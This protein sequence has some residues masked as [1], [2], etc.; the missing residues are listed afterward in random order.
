M[1]SL[2]RIIFR[3]LLALM[4]CTAGHTASAQDCQVS[5]IAC[6]ATVRTMLVTCAAAA[7]VEGAIPTFDWNCAGAAAS[8]ASCYNMA[9]Y[10]AAD[11]NKRT[12]AVSSGGARGKVSSPAK[13]TTKTCSELS[14][15]YG[16]RV[17][18]LEFKK[19]TISNKTSISSIRMTC[20]SGKTFTFIGNNGDSGST[21]TGN[22]CG[23][24][25]MMQGLQVRHTNS[26]SV[27]ALGTVCDNVTKS[28]NDNTNGTFFGG[29]TGTS[30]TLTCSE[31]KYLLGLNVYT[32]PTLP[33]SSRI[34]DGVELLCMGMK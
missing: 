19:A 25:N 28:S 5:A 4:L 8:T 1:K 17:N 10:C 22:S 16:D 6:A 9:K 20:T 26:V 15:Y 12:P 30:E 33:L 31:G 21:W 13:V 18:Q 29:G 2:I 34:A 11:P 7:V 3:P 32:T 14:G 27:N 23:N 24:G